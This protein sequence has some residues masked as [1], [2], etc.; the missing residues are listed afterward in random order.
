MKSNKRAL[1]RRDFLGAT[2]ATTLVSTATLAGER[3]GRSLGKIRSAYGERS[4]Y[5]KSAR[6]FSDSTVAVQSRSSRTPLQDLYGVI[7]PSSLHF[8]RH[9][10]GVPTL[11][12]NEHRLHIH[13]LVE[14]PLTLTMEDIARFP[15]VS[16][17]HFIECGGNAG[18]E[19]AGNPGE[20]VQLSHGL[21]SCSEWT[22][23]R[24]GVLLQEVGITTSAKWILA[25][26]ADAGRH[27]RSIPIDK[28]L[29]DVIVAYGQ[30]GEAL[31]PE[32]GYP[33]RL[34]APGWEGNVSVKWLRRLHVLAEPAM[35][36][37]EAASYTDLLPT[38]KARR[39]SFEMEAN[40]VITR[41]SGG[42]RLGALGFYEISGFA[43]S[44]RGRVQRVEVSIDGGRL[45]QEAQ[46]QAPIYSKALTRFRM[47]WRWRGEETIVQ[48]RCTDE[49]GY[50]Q[51]TRTEL[52]AVRG[53]KMG[54]DGFDHY[55]GIKPW[56]IAADGTVTHV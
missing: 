21:L 26:G 3:Q 35:T 42:Q 47:P 32:Q 48:S 12:P 46:L 6:L 30:N 54:P 39:F 11:N 55:N 24:L 2:T 56:K 8:E 17:I 45:W 14:R 49:T 15:S 19:H 28:A 34:L 10:S 9:H 25:E 44:G 53:M 40:S 43:W 16:R 50:V 51:P 7:T 41:P 38:G 1:T 22:G 4:P 33:L 5:E 23:V 20:T 36:R 52:I 27:A 31:R 18:R 29:D 37:D 13:G